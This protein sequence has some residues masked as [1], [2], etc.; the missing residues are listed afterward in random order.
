MLL[1]ICLDFAISVRLQCSPMGEVRSYL[2]TKEAANR[3]GVSVK[4]LA[5]WRK[6]R[7]GPEFY[8]LGRN[9]VYYN[10]SDI[11]SWLESCRVSFG[12]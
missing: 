2:G 6:R 9:M 5:L 8:K 3:I 1:V 11:E 7:Y 4:T 10:K 12:N